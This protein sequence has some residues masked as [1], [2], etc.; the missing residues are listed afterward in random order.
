MFDMQ[1]ARSIPRAV[2]V[3]ACFALVFVALALVVVGFLW[4]EKLRRDG[5]SDLQPAPNTDSNTATD[6][7]DP[8]IVPTSLTDAGSSLVKRAINRCDAEAASDPDGLHF[9]LTPVVPVD[10][11]SATMLLPPGL[12]YRSFYL[13]PQTQAILSGLEDGPLDLST[14]PYEFS[15]IDSQTGRIQKWTSVNGPSQLTLSPAGELLRFQ[16]GLSFGDEGVTWTNEF[17]RRKG[18][19][20]LVN[21]FFPGQAYSPAPGRSIRRMKSFPSPAQTL[22]CANR[23]CEQDGDLDVQNERQ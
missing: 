12:N 21:L 6:L 2:T 22:R 3:I 17:Y 23:A 10:F 4:S 14:R 16:I 8:I 18:N 19:C 11:D 1:S 13:V 15:L 5:R 20:Y 9:L 7:L